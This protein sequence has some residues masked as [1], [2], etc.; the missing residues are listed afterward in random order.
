MNSLINKHIHQICSLYHNIQNNNSIEELENIIN[1][2]S[3]LIDTKR[4]MNIDVRKIIDL[5]NTTLT[6]SSKTSLNI[7][8]LK[9]NLTIVKGN[10]NE[11]Y[12]YKIYTA[13][14][15]TCLTLFIKDGYILFTHLKSFNFLKNCINR[16]YNFQTIFVFFI[17]NL[18]K[19]LNCKILEL[20]DYSY[21][22]KIIDSKQSLYD[23]KTK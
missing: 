15:D 23:E 4:K 14:D 17:E 18:S 6:T 5:L 3:S 13:S 7:N 19:Q 21:F 22:Q 2:T 12:L 11:D 8:F 10:E 16:P 20:E 1:K 9:K